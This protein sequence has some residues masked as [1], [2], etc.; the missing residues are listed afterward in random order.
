MRRKS[1][2]SSRA[3]R[4]VIALGTSVV[5]ALAV[6]A[7]ATSASAQEQRA[8]TGRS[9]DGWLQEGWR[10]KAA[11]DTA[12]AIRAFEQA[13][14]AGADVQIVSLELGYLELR[15]GHRGAARGYFS[16]AA[17]GPDRERAEIARRELRYL[18]AHL[19]ADVYAEAWGWHRFAGA[20][21]TDLVPT[22]R[23]RALVRPVLDFD[24]SGFLYAQGTRDV[25]SQGNGTVA[26]SRIYADNR[27]TLGAG[28]LLRL[29]QGRI[30]VFAQGGY[31][32]NLLND[33]QPHQWDVR[34]GVI[35]MGQT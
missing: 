27:L 8:S 21:S 31:A 15:R 12:G 35:L 6:G 34:A 9:A 23:V 30:G 3:A 29:W 20:P 24:L 33:S 1:P 11:A 17:A 5:L 2:V 22:L 18:P 32:F 4:R 10:L 7:H 26:L 14:A 28:L 19:W 25:A 16:T 13:R